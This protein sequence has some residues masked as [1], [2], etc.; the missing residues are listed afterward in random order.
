MDTENGFPAYDKDVAAWAID[1]A[2]ALR[3]R[4]FANLDWDN[5]ADEILDVAKAEERELGCRVS[6]LMASLAKSN[7]CGSTPG[8]G[9]IRVVQEQRKLV[10]LQLADTPSLQRCMNDTRWLLSC[11][12]DAVIAL[13]EAG[14]PVEVL[15]E[16][17]PWNEATLM[18]DLAAK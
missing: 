11:W 4:N 6:S 14:I 10:L 1:Q 8:P 2:Q 13:F 18:D 12:S 17:N 15:P 5:L 7:L 9:E 16:E 3:D